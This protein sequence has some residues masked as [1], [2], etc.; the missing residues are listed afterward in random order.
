MRRKVTEQLVAEGSCGNI[1]SIPRHGDPQAGVRTEALTNIQN[2]PA[3]TFFSS[4]AV[5]LIQID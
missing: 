3:G 2:V 1:V 4:L 5:F